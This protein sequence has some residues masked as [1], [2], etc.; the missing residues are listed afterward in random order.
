MRS[1]SASETVKKLAGTYGSLGDN[2]SAYVAALKSGDST[3]S[4]LMG[5]CGEWL[6]VNKQIEREYRLQAEVLSI[7]DR[8]Y[9]SLATKIG[10]VATSINQFGSGLV[11]GVAKVT[12]MAVGIDHLTDVSLRFNKTMF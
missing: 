5:Q 6:K 3:Q 7:L 1:L 4:K 8:K 2:L 12:G 10:R 9:D 11:S